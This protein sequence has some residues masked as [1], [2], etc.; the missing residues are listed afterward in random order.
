MAYYTI[1]SPAGATCANF[2]G[3]SDIT[4]LSD[5]SDAVATANAP[6]GSSAWSLAPISGYYPNLPKGCITTGYMND[7]SYPI[8]GFVLPY[9]NMDTTGSGTGVSYDSGNFETCTTNLSAPSPT[10]CTYLHCGR[11]P[12]PSSPPLLPPPSPPLPLQPPSPPLSL[13]P[14]SPTSPLSEPP[15][16]QQPPA[17]P[18]LVHTPLFDNVEVV[19]QTTRAVTAAAVASIAVSVGA[20][21]AAG[22]ASAAAGAAGAAGA[23]GA[24]ASAAGGAGGGAGG[25][26]AGAAAGGTIAPLILGVQRFSLTS[27]LAVE[28]SGMQQGVADSLSWA[29]GDVPFLSSPPHR[30]LQMLANATLSDGSARPAELTSLLNL[31]ITASIGL[32]ISLMIELFLV[33][34]WRCCLN[35]RYYREQDSPTTDKQPAKF[36]PFPKSLMWPTPLFFAFFACATGLTRASTLLL[37]A[38]P[39]NCGSVCHLL[40]IIVLAV[41]VSII[42]LILL[43]LASFY[44][45]QGSEV[46][47][48]PSAKLKEPNSLTDPWMRMRAKLLFKAVS[49]G[50]TTRVAIIRRFEKVATVRPASEASFKRISTL[51]QRFE[52]IDQEIKAAEQQIAAVDRRLSVKDARLERKLKMRDARVKRQLTTRN[53]RAKAIDALSSK[54]FRDRKTGAWT[55]P[56]IDAVEPARTERILADPFGVHR[57]RAGD[58]WQALEG[59][60]L[61]RVNGSSRLAM[62]Y[63]LIVLIVNMIFGVLS[64]LH[65]LLPPGNPAA[66]AQ[67]SSVLALQLVM[68]A[69]C[70]SFLPDADRIVSRFAGAQFLFE[71]AATAALLGA[72]LEGKE[73]G[74]PSTGL[75][76]QVVG[77]F[78]SLFAMGVPIFQLLEQ[79]CLT[80]TINLVMKRATADP[81]ILLSQ[82]YMMAASLPRQLVNLISHS[83]EGASL[84][85]AAGNASADAGDDAMGTESSIRLGGGNDDADGAANGDDLHLQSFSEK[86]VEPALKAE[87][88]A[89][90]GV[91][92]SR[93]LARAFAAKEAAGKQVANARTSVGEFL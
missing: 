26:A 29:S 67:A 49:S 30:R 47:W 6:Y 16:V 31:L 14:P 17:S 50:F 82:V 77:F 73:S 58:R 9:F 86:S 66:I 61:F 81:I 57:N 65:P 63:R 35:R 21:V 90:M 75:P 74:L 53:A 87:D 83:S 60:L 13:Q 34:L 25:G 41:L 4:S 46:Q 72:S 8:R 64:G 40:P 68:S 38:N 76:L 91:K 37:A 28:Q 88:A 71:G 1:T 89:L 24:A 80:P 20:S 36:F 22:V 44:R 10:Y 3:W 52:S 11:P 42:V 55:L 70:F 59:F 19:E 92:A 15:V 78:L 23:G 54:G 93:L 43:H 7:T 27:G 48:K 39:P 18:P 79:R 45:K 5:C 56:P 51:E 33:F 84:A 12:P 69:I 2:S 85:D 32:F 62:S